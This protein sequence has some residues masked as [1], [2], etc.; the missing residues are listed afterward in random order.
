MFIVTEHNS[1]QDESGKV[2]YFSTD[3]FIR[4]IV[5]GD[6]CFMCGVPP[7]E[8]E[9]SQEHIIPKWILRKFGLFSERITLPNGTQ[10]RY[11]QY[12]VPCCLACNAF[13]GRHVE[14]PTAAIVDEGYDSLLRH[15]TSQGPWMLFK[16][17]NLL[18][19]KTHLKDLALRAHR[20]RRQPAASIGAQYSWGDLHHIHCVARSPYTGCRIDENCLGSVFILP[21]KLIPGPPPFDYADLYQSQ[22]VLVQ[23]GDVA[24]I[25]NL[26]DCRLAGSALAELL[27]K[28]KGPLSPPQLREFLA[29]AAYMNVRLK[30][31]PL[32][33]SDFCQNEGAY[34]ILV[35]RGECPEMEPW[36]PSQF[37]A[38]HS[39]ACTGA[40]DQFLTDEVRQYIKEGRYSFIVDME[41][42]FL[43]SNPVDVSSP[44]G[45]RS[46]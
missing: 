45:N 2:L 38:V 28:I 32:F 37:G 31:R 8:A 20:D 25:A 7:A 17:L 12:V 26:T 35:E 4:S 13:L 5:E 39:A 3:H 33:M 27:H 46:R 40:V 23:I 16:W 21:A 34:S 41:G 18:F 6:S 19:I 36:D 22:S 10:V 30:N 43:E 29:L 44:P 24:I 11:D 14:E 9:F 1:V 42:N 15:I